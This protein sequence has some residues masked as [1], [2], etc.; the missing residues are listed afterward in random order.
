MDFWAGLLVSSN[1][2]GKF[3]VCTDLIGKRFSSVGAEGDNIYVSCLD[4][5]HLLT[6][7]DRV[8]KVADLA[9]KGISCGKG[10]VVAASEDGQLYSWGTQGESGQLGQGAHHRKIFEPLEISYKANIAS[11]SCGEAHTVAID[12]DGKGYAWGEV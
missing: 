2:D 6:L 11:I 8:M 12:A 10:F 3:E 1:D 9:C 5:V 4:A 7:D